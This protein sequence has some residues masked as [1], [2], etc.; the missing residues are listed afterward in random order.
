MLAY[1]SWGLRLGRI[2]NVSIYFFNAFLVSGML[3]NAKIFGG[4]DSYR[5]WWLVSLNPS[6]ILDPSP[7]LTLLRSSFGSQPWFVW[8]SLLRSWRYYRKKNFWADLKV[9][10]LNF[11]NWRW[12][13]PWKR[14]ITNFQDSIVP[15]LI[16]EINQ[17]LVR[18][19]FC[20]SL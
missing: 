14:A 10:I 2:S 13:N 18:S 17:N 12:E 19:K 4:I 6:Y 3:E 1:I 16:W 8:P 11:K 20:F 5:H 9:N 15:L 7:L